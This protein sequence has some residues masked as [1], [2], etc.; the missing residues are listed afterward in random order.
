MDSTGQVVALLFVDTYMDVIISTLLKYIFNITLITLVLLVIFCAMNWIVMRKNFIDPI[1][2]IR[3][4]VGRFAKN[5]AQA[6]ASL[7]TIKTADEIEDLA[8]S[9]HDMECEIINYIDDI[10]NITAERERIG[11]EL[12]VATRIQADMLPSIFPPFPDRQAFDIYAIMSPA[13][14]V[15][16]DFYDF[17]LLDDDHI[18]MVMADVSG[19]GV[20]AALFMVIAKTLIKNRSMMGDKMS[21][22]EILYDVNNQLCEGNDSDMFVTVWLCIIEL[23]TGKG[24]AS[25]AGHE[26]PAIKHEGGQYSFKEY[27]HS[28]A[29]AAFP[30]IQFEEHE[31]RLEPGDSIFVYT[32]GVIEATNSDDDLYGTK[33]LLDALNIEPE[34][35]AQKLLANV[36]KNVEEFVGA[37]SQF[38]DMTMMCFKYYGENE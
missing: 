14:E 10:K 35:D 15:G 34:A 33:R 20:P 30:D 8:K 26:H 37:T 31:F 18:A 29:V 24:I 16:G 12:N 19:K 28:L 13:K 23:S 27:K 25:N 4:S 2:L 6:D 17:F 5:N 7:T 22:S 1:M 38:D 3:D 36:K 9:V 11:A 32:D 21:P